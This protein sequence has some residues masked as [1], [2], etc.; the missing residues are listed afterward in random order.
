M[1]NDEL[2]LIIE[3]SLGTEPGFQL[4]SGF[5]RMVTASVMRKDQLRNDLREYFYMTIITISLL[6]VAGGLYYYADKAMILQ[7]FNFISDNVF[8]VL[9]ATFLLNFVLFADKVLLP[10]LFNRSNHIRAE[11]KGH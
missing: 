3:K 9:F 10:L 2:D 1:K 11:E 5:A 8:P 7:L 6:A 4:P